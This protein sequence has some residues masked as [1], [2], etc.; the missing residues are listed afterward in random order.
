MVLENFR[1]TTF[2]HSSLH[3]LPGMSPESDAVPIATYIMPLFT[4]ESKLTIDITNILGGVMFPFATSFLLPVS[5]QWHYNTV[6]KPSLF[7]SYSV[8]SLS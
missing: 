7:L 2:H 6:I 8:S 4:Q 5:I 3:L 1:T